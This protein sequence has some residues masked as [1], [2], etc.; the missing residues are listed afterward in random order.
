M[1]GS[2]IILPHPYW[3]R[4]PKYKK[5]RLDWPTKNKHARK[6]LR[7]KGQWVS[8][9]GSSGQGNLEFW[10]EYEAPTFCES[11]GIS[12]GLYPRMV[13]EPD[14]DFG[15]PGLNTDPW[16]FYPGFVWSVC[17]HKSIRKP[18]KSGDIVLFGSSVKGEWY[19]DTLMVI[20]ERTESG[21]GVIGGLYDNMIFSKLTEPYKPIVGESFTGF[22]TPFSFV[23]AK[24]SETGHSP[25][26]RPCIS[27]LFRDLRKHSDNQVPSTKNCQ[28]LV[29]CSYEHGNVAFW[30][31]VAMLVENSNLLLG[32]RFF[33]VLD[34]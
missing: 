27:S 2:I 18:V 3:E 10:G 28:A 11:T 6:F 21:E 26:L 23:P 1:S 4:L 9:D 5:T 19:L 15:E 22:D 31:K 7:S 24:S 33:H 20:K 12:E 32:T 29:F 17:R 30:R 8:L 14:P 25:F 34:Y 16:V 13:Q